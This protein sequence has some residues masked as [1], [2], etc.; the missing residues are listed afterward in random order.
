MKELLIKL[1]NGLD[2]SESEAAL[3]MHQMMEGSASPVEISAY[4]TLLRTKGETIPE[5]TGSAKAMRDHALA[6]NANHDSLID[7]C[8]TGG[9][10][11]GTFNISTTSAIVAAAAGVPVA[12][13]GNRAASSKSGSAD[14]LQALGVAIELGPEQ[15]ETCLKQTGISF[16]FAQ[17]FHPAMKQV[18]PVRK[19]LGFRTMFNI[20]GPLTNPARPKRQVLGTPSLAIAEKMANVLLNLGM[21]HALVVHSED[22]LD[23]LSISGPTHCYEVKGGQVLYMVLHPEDFGLS[24]APIQQV[25]GGTPEENANLIERIL[26]GEKGAPRDIVIMNAAAAIYVS[27]LANSFPSAAYIAEAAIDSGAAL[28]TLDRL[29][30]ISRNLLG[31]IG[32]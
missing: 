28:E 22:G 15:A 17:T 26:H 4:L 29:R 23:E 6:V 12:K 19:A 32:A 21:E 20:L 25:Q 14:V 7:T 24:S 8:G 30:N 13:H 31:E 11:A 3:A 1:S 27:G 18:A 2:L 5:L 16:L 10:N 9:D